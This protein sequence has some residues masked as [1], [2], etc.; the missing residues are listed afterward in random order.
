[1]ILPIIHM[2]GTSRQELIDQ[3]TAVLDTIRATLTALGKM[4]P[5]GRDYYP[6]PGLWDL[7]DQVHGTRIYRLKEIHDE[8]L[9]E[10]IAI[11]DSE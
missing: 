5:N 9:A 3:R 11:S 2:N 10:A 4:S 7:A 6:V 8:I 1:M